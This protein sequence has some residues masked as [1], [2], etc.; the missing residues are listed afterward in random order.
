MYGMRW[1]IET[2]FRDLKYTVFF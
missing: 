1:G 2:S